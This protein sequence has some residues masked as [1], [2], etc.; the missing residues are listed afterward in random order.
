MS[1]PYFT[2]NDIPVRSSSC[3][4]GSFDVNAT[5]MLAL[6]SSPPLPKSMRRSQPRPACVRL[7]HEESVKPSP[8][9]TIPVRDVAVKK[10]FAAPVKVYAPSTAHGNG[11]VES[12]GGGGEGD[13]GEGEGEG[14]GGEGGG[15]GEGG[16]G[17]GGG[18]GE[19]GGG[20]GEGEGGGGEGEG[21]GGEGGGGEGEGGGGDGEWY[22]PS[23]CLM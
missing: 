15:E 13:G 22:Q 17:E 16:G 5:L 12:K 10:E 19:G 18:E 1:L 11:G 20:E 7:T 9:P 2:E 23:R 3:S 14:G 21:G 4:S 6:S 8:P